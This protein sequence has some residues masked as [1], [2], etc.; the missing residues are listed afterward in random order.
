MDTLPLAATAPPHPSA[1]LP[2]EA[3]QLLAPSP[4]M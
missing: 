4:T 2:P 1:P 3:E